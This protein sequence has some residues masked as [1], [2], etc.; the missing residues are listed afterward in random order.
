[1]G[2]ITKFV[3]LLPTQRICS[4]LID[5]RQCTH[6][7]IVLL[8]LLLAVL[9][10][11]SHAHGDVNAC[12]VELKKADADQDGFIS[13]SEFVTL[14]NWVR[15][16]GNCQPD[17]TSTKLS[18]FERGQY[19]TSAHARCH[20][21][22]ENYMEKH[23]CKT[24][25]T[26]IINIDV[27]LMEPSTRSEAE[28]NTLLFTCEALEATHFDV[29]VDS[30]DACLTALKA[31]DDDISASVSLSEY[32]KFV[33]EYNGCDKT[34]PLTVAH[35]SA[36]AWLANEGCF[37]GHCLPDAFIQTR[38]S[39]VGR[40]RDSIEIFCRRTKM[41]GCDGGDTSGHHCH[42]DDC[43]GHDHGDEDDEHSH[44]S[45]DHCKEALT[46]ANKDQTGKVSMD[47]FFDFVTELNG[48]SSSVAD[49]HSEEHLAAYRLAAWGCRLDG[50]CDKTVSAIHIANLTDTR[51][52]TFC[53]VSARLGCGGEAGESKAAHVDD[54]HSHSHGHS[55]S[56]S[57]SHDADDEDDA[58]AVTSQVVQEE[59][60]GV[61]FRRE[62]IASSVG[63][64]LAWFLL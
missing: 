59:D 4:Q 18:I 40:D 7:I 48:C 26:A 58:Q 34:M 53:S 41:L 60:S 25:D 62:T 63:F 29:C 57:H 46:A 21:L 11:S 8:A 35:E 23:L 9:P 37:L 14:L 43:H 52:E 13:Q 16:K 64:F 1:M 6:P 19:L 51:F 27:A 31:A 30:I 2:G 5:M 54:S 32:P 39:I 22:S 17:T 10:N 12:A 36:F 42:G 24:N 55:H 56:H 47:E 61:S 50:T 20:F 33:K 38:P 49:E 15:S 44:S 45:I 3:E 28:N